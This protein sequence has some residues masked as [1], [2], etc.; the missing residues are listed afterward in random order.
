MEPTV[1]AICKTY[2]KWYEAELVEE[3]KNQF[4]I[5]RGLAH[6]FLALS[7]TAVFCYSATISTT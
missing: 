4:L 1:S 3:N 5:P 2:G 6:G 7:D